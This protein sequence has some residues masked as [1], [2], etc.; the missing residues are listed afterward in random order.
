RT[1]STTQQAAA[2]VSTVT[3]SISSLDAALL[4]QKAVADCHANNRAGEWVFDTGNLAPTIMG[5]DKVSDFTGYMMGDVDGDWS[6]TGL[7]RSMENT[8]P[9]P[10]AGIGSLPTVQADVGTQVIVPFRIDNLAGKST[11]STQFTITYDPTVVLAGPGAASVQGT[12]ANN[13]GVV[14]NV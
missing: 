6:E 9:S 13:L 3:T 5:T 2:H 7:N 8:D 1:F 14:S 10:N 11:R 4:A 12:N